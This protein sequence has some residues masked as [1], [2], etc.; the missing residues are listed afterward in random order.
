MEREDAITLHKN[1]FPVGDKLSPKSSPSLSLS[2]SLS[3]CFLSVSG[4]YSSTS[5]NP[6]VPAA[7]SERAVCSALLS[8]P[9][10]WGHQPNGNTNGSVEIMR[11][12]HV[13]VDV[14]TPPG[15]VA[16]LH[17]APLHPSDH[18]RRPLHPPIPSGSQRQ[19][20]DEARVLW[21]TF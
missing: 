10:H 14:V 17:T 18:L 13:D 8:Q 3:F 12:R 9:S 7:G 4:S 11:T 21:P 19:T 1:R 5:H 15:V 6:S 2:L 20:W 16:G